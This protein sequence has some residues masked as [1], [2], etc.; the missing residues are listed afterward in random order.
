[1]NYQYLLEHP[2][3]FPYVIG[4]N[5]GQFESILPRFSSA[6]R[7]AEHKKAYEEFEERMGRE[8]L[9]PPGI[10]RKPTLKT[11]RQKLFFV[12]FYYKVYPTFRFAQCIFNFD[13]RNIQLWKEFLE[14]VLFEALGYQLELPIVRVNSYSGW[15]E[16]C[17]ALRE[18]LVD[19]T[20]RRIRRP[21]DSDDQELYYSGKKKCHTVKNQIIVH[22]RKRRILSVSRTVEGK[23][24]DKKLLEQDQTMSRAPP[25]AKG[26]GD[27]GYQG[28]GEI[29]PLIS[30]LT[31][32]KKPKNKELSPSDK[33]TNRVISSIRV[34]VEHPFAYMKHFN[35][36]THPFRNRIPK[37]HQPFV[38]IACIY[39]YTRTHH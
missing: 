6:L 18:F 34:R 30:F 36:L 33:E 5:H 24:S 12:L 17:P 14:P 20:E 38:S 23:R 35:I 22:P 10:G 16:V 4:I 13:K 31:P 7:K 39:N 26:L 3:L 2:D 28:A 15:M 19:S 32:I 21:K 1:M 11:D 8:R 25:K 27:L 9:Q 37:A 29:N